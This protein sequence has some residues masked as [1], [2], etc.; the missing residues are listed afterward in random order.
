MSVAYLHYIK[1]DHIKLYNSTYIDILQCI[2]LNHLHWPQLLRVGGEGGVGS[3][4]REKGQ[5]FFRLICASA[6]VSTRFVT[7]SISNKETNDEFSLSEFP[8][9]GTQIV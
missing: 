2:I 8:V 7:Q 6:I 3:I 1:K 9:G 5:W 4:K